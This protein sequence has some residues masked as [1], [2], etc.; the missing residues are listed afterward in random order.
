MN[1]KDLMTK[2][3]AIEEGIEVI[4]GPMP[5]MGHPVEPPKQQDNVT[6]NVSLN[7][8][9][10]GGV[11]DLMKILKDIEDGPASDVGQ[12]DADPEEPIMGDMIDAMSHAEE[13]EECYVQPEE[14]MG[15]T[16]EDD[17][18]DWGNSAEGGSGHHVG[19]V[20]SVT[21][22]GDDMNS[23][24]KLN[25]HYSPGNNTLRQ[26]TT[27]HESLVDKLTAMYEEIKGEQL[28]ENDFEKALN[29]TSG[30]F[31]GW[32]PMHGK[33]YENYGP[34]QGHVKQAV[35]HGAQVYHYDDGEGGY[36]ATGEVVHDKHN[37]VW[38]AVLNKEPSMHKDLGS[39]M[40]AIRTEIGENGRRHDANHQN[41]SDNLER[42]P[43]DPEKHLYK[44]D[45]AGK[46]GM[47]NKGRIDTLTSPYRREINGPQGVLPEQMNESKE[48]NDIIALTKIL[49]G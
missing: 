46:K 45:R 20:D 18:E 36:D 23:K 37:G 3:D 25:P 21:F 30:G 40:D 34:Y 8:S 29:S 9:G 10:A 1:F 12:H 13:E 48:L 22:S 49:K 31:T 38:Y 43:F 32:E 33:T 15:E 39:L 4:G 44:T 7:G 11:K 5:A 2:L 42:D 17:H 6:M 14:S 28:H 47:L 16:F 26:S 19:G 24:A 35:K 41:R 27:M